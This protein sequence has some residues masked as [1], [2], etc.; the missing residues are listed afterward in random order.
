MNLA[1]RSEV[2]ARGSAL[3]SFSQCVKRLSAGGDLAVYSPTYGR[4]SS[5][6][7]MWI[8]RTAAKLCA[9]RTSP[10]HVVE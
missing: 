5:L 3:D 7:G 2:D 10:C 8:P 6:S 9:G 1:S 4:P